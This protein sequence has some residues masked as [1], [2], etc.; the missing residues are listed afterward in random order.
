M[1]LQTKVPIKPQQ[2]TIDYQAQVLLLGSC[3]VENMGHLLAQYQFKTTQNPFGVLFHPLAIQHLVSRAVNNEKFTITDVFEH[4]SRWQSFQ[5]HSSLSA[6]D[7]GTCVGLL[8]KALHRTHVALKAAS[9][10]IVTFGTAWVYNH[11]ETNNVVANC[12]K[13]P[14]KHFKKELLSVA[15]IQNTI[16]NM[17]TAINTINP[18]ATIVFTV[19]PVRHLKDGFIENTQSKAHLFAAIH[20]FLK[21]APAQSKNYYHYFPAYEIMMDELRDYRFYEPDM[22]HPNTTA[23]AYIWNA[24]KTAWI[25]ETAWPT[26]D[27]VASIQ[28]GLQHKPFN[29]ASEAHQ[30]FLKKLQAQQRDLKEKFPHMTF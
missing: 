19:S 27:L 14:Q 29:P 20:Q 1:K 18:L 3:F 9:H 7:S 22:I 21:D 10:I 23:I 16:Q 4:N 15:A 6:T 17:V 25:S 30:A 5:A 8:N 13:V 26:M 2:N 24:F 12:H 11:I 28:K